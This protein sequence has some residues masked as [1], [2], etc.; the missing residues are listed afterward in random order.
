V[1]T[2][3]TIKAHEA[4]LRRLVDQEMHRVRGEVERDLKSHEIRLRVQADLG[5]KLIDRM[6]ND[7]G[8][9]RM[10]LVAAFNSIYLLTQEAEP[11][12][13]TA[14]FAELVEEA[15][16][17]FTAVPTAAPYVPPELSE[18]A[19]LLFDE[20]HECFLNVVR[21]A[22]LPTREERTARC[23][24]TNSTIEDVAQRARKLFGDWQRQQFAMLRDG[25][26]DPAGGLPKPPSAKP[27]ETADE[28]GG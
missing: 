10:K 25:L 16:R 12:G 14:R 28:R 15:R 26:A 5:L 3:Q 9:Y 1:Q 22:K 4:E 7:V 18:Q 8:Q 21:W 17:T 13:S 6:L 19:I 27:V 24:N 2:E 20:A 11:N 23:M